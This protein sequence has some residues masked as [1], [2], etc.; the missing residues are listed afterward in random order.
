MPDRQN[1]SLRAVV[2]TDFPPGLLDLKIQVLDRIVEIE[3]GFQSTIPEIHELDKVE[4]GFLDTLT[5]K[6]TYFAQPNKD[7]EVL[8]GGRNQK[9][10]E[11]SDEEIKIVINSYFQEEDPKLVV[12]IGD[13]T[14]MEDIDMLPPQ[15]ISF[16]KEKYHLYDDEITIKTKY[17]LGSKSNVKIGG[18]ESSDYGYE[19]EPVDSE[20]N[21]TIS[22]SRWLEA[23]GNRNPDFVF[24]GIG[25]I[26]VALETTYGTSE[27]N[28]KVFAP[29]IES[30]SD[31]TYFYKSLIR[32]TGL[33]FGYDDVSKVYIDDTELLSRVTQTMDNTISLYIS[34]ARQLITGYA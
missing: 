20:G 32:L 5:I 4:T 23:I 22:L 14:L 16:D 2:T 11:S 24:E 1:D 34:H 21:L 9:I 3:S 27:M 19:L 18:A 15:I 8:V 31:D 12:N 17:F 28:F 13:F 29:L 7:L 33:D 25:T 26:K 10:L 30:L 6:G